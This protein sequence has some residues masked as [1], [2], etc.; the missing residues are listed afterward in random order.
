MT[1]A[2]APTP[3]PAGTPPAG[4]GPVM[5]LL[6]SYAYARNR[7]MDQ[8]LGD[9]QV[10]RLRFFADSG[11]HSAR[12]LGITIDVDTYAEWLR[13]WAPWF[14]IYANL[15][16]IWSP[17]ETWANQRRLED[18]H[19]LHPMPVFHTG[20]PFEALD[21]YLAEGYSYIAL[22]KLLGNRP[23]VL[24]PWIA[25]CFRRAGDRA[26][27]H[28]FGLTTMS[29]LREFPFHSVD[30]S[31]WGE[32]VRFGYLKLFHKG[33][34]HK[35]W[36]RRRDDVRKHRAV[37]DAYRIPYSALT[38][39]GFD[40]DLV[41]GVCAASYYRASL[42]LRQR[43]GPIPLPPGRGY[44]PPGTPTVAKV[45]PAGDPGPRTFLADSTTT[46]HVRHAGG[47]HLYLADAQRRWSAAAAARIA[48]EPPT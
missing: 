19:G 25:E 36:L 31:S 21:R 48:Q 5:N 2:P 12:T 23:E 9:L 43:H 18:R 33:R 38:A 37:L 24:R 42:W 29:L 22:G 3:A 10:D 6:W 30:S 26:V 39:G 34:W 41:A 46:G 13:T 20:E 28:G 1:P 40:R 27:F 44:P 17:T 8:F 15:D 4:Q 32:G 14:T 47:L 45:V 7:P 16:V 35:I 11:A